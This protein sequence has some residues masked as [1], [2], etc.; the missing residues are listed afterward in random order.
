VVKITGFDAELVQLPESE[1]E[2]LNQLAAFFSEQ[3]LLR[4]FS[5]L[6]KTEQDIKN[7][8]QPRFQLEVGLV[9]LAQA[10]KLFLLEDAIQR[11]EALESRV[12]G[13]SAAPPSAGGRTQS[14]ARDPRQSQFQSRPPST[15]TRAPSP[16]RPPENQSS[17]ARSTEEAVTPAKASGSTP[18]VIAA[19]AQPQTPAAK[20]DAA[21]PSE[22]PPPLDKRESTIAPAREKGTS[23]S[24]PID[25]IKGALEA[26]RK[27]M[28]VT[29]LDK[30]S[31]TID[32][33]YFRVTYESGNSHCKGQI[34][35]RDKRIAIEDACEEVLGRRLT[36]WA[37]VAGES[38]AAQPR[39]KEK[40]KEAA[41]SDPKL[42]ALVDKFHGEVIEVIKPEQ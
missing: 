13:G 37:S 12:G 32:A 30:G 26:K 25:K 20:P 23:A 41:V 35:A 14:A 34:E 16:P 1:A 42:R 5:I 4:F 21:K 24:D 3:D 9:K 22:P 6:T 28:I 39:R 7:S 29:A 33:D 11:I 17:Q 15:S 40:A 38:E 8:A 36:L 31:I 2:A 27:M 19:V 18:P 10:R